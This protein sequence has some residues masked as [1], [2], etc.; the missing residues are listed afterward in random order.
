[1]T[2]AGWGGC[3]VSIVK[4]EDV[5]KL[6]TGV[7]EHY[8]MVSPSKASKVEAALFASAPAEGAAFYSA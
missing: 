4:S 1:M 7:R 5:A 6:L 8:Y 3:A 2:G